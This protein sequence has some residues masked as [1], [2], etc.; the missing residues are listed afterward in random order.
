MT[1]RMDICLRCGT[2]QAARRRRR[3]GQPVRC[4]CGHAMKRI[5]YA[6]WAEL[7]LTLAPGEPSQRQETQTS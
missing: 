4:E 1:D 7:L 3:G 6:R 5:T 2:W